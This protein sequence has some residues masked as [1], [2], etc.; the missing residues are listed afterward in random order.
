MFRIKRAFPFILSA[1]FLVNCASQMSGFA[2]TE[3]FELD[4]S[5]HKT[6]PLAQNGSFLLTNHNGRIEIESWDREE[7]DI[8][9]TE[10]YHDDDYTIEIDI[11]ARSDR[12]RVEAIHPEIRDW[13]FW[14]NRRRPVADFM[15]K[16]PRE[17]RVDAGSHNGSVRITGISGEVETTAHNGDVTVRDI[18]GDLRV[19]SHNGEVMV[20]QVEGDLRVTAYNGDIE[21]DRING[22]IETRSHN[23]TIRLRDVT[24]GGIFAESYNGRIDGDFT[25]DENGMYEFE[26]SNGTIDIRIPGDSK[27]NVDVVAR[28]RNFRTDFDE[29]ADLEREQERDR[30]YDRTLRINGDING[31]GARL[32]LRTNNGSVRLRSK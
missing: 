15:V 25:V 12:V 11:D 3:R 13:N 7:V 14:N 16:V 1:L 4:G 29:L 5:L 23:G 30:R 21:F 2:Q 9:I 26:T 18:I 17:V 32:R 19:D 27:A 8:E 6:Y 31:G 28:G 10:R 20:E 22:E 24:G